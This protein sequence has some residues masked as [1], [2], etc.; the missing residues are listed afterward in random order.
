MD[1]DAASIHST[2]DK[3]R[4]VL[5]N[6]SRSIVHPAVAGTVPSFSQSPPPPTG[7]A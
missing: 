7:L 6:I 1:S 2:E 4:Y 5:R 3:V